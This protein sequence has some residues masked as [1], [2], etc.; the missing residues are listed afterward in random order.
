MAAISDDDLTAPAPDKNDPDAALRTAEVEALKAK[1]QFM[2]LSDAL[3]G[4]FDGTVANV[5][6][7]GAASYAAVER[8]EAAFHDVVDSTRAANDGAARASANVDAVASATEEIN[9]SVRIVS[10]QIEKAASK[11]D[12][13]ADEA[14]T[15]SNVIKT[16]ADA[17]AEISEVVKLIEG[18]AGQTNLLALNATIE[19]ARAGEAGKG[20]AVVAGEVKNLATKTADA[21]S[22]VTERIGQIQSVT[23]HAVA[24][25]AKI[26]SAA[27][28][29]RELSEDA[30]RAAQEQITAIQS[31]ARN[32]QEAS[33]GTAEVGQAILWPRRRR[34]PT[35]RRWPKNRN[36]ASRRCNKATGT[37]KGASASPS[38]SPLTKR[39]P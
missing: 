30:A 36:A 2:T 3:Q 38:W 8:M 37:C 11:A 4:E 20:F 6:D 27:A 7:A 17:A 31:I 28:E 24:A 29:A 19:A 39:P 34:W 13:A 12:G 35:P 23:D 15:A 16:L 18:I 14:E 33:Q 10:E 1:R 22:D 21:T 26:N 32:A 25:I 9:G 5:R